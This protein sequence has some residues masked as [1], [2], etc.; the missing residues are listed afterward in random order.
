MP[1]DF[2]LLAEKVRN[3][4]RWAPMDQ[5]GTLNLIGPEALIR[6]AS[7]VSQGKA[8]SLGIDFGI[9][10]P[11]LGDKRFNPRLFATDL[12][13]PI[14]PNNPNVMISD[15]V[16]VM[17]LQ[18]ATQ[19]DA[20][21]HVHFNGKLYGGKTAS[22]HLSPS[23]TSHCGIEHMAKPGIVS[24]A[25]LLDV[26]R[27][28]NTPRLEPG[29]SISIDDLIKACDLAQLRPEPGD[30]VCI[31][32]GHITR[33]TIDG[34]RA[35]FN[36]PQPGLSFHVAEWLHERQVAAVAADNLAVEAL[37]ADIRSQDIPL[38]L[39]CLALTEMGMP[40]GEIWNFEELA[41]D[42]AD[43]GRYAFLLCA[44]PLS[45]PGAF[46]SPVNPIAMK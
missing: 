12:F 19:W 36:G 7:A 11:Q 14:N 32:T 40:L 2:E 17:P 5:R 21:G 24:R 22:E 1:Q 10:G 42:C 34:D 29:H 20:L 13:S 28:Y 37:T 18:A 38:P 15:D 23:G 46:G 31:R 16:I 26:A 45:I 30:V 41:K 4:G 8:F 43:D 33:F 6:G 44:P 39:H 35:A 25:I 3:W 27:L 9:N